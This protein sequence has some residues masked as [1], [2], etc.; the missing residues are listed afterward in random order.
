MHKKIWIV[1]LAAF[2]CIA[3]SEELKGGDS[4]P[5]IFYKIKHGDTLNKLSNKYFKQPVD[6]EIIRNLNNLRTIDLL[7][8]GTTL[9]IP[10][11][12]VKQ[13]P[14][15]A[16][17]IGL[18]CPRTI[19]AGVP[20]KTITIGS[21]LTEGSI[22]DVPAECHASMLLED[23][24]IVRLPSS[25]AIKISTLRR[26]ALE[27]SPEVQLDLVRGK[28]DL[29]VNKA[30]KQN[31]P[32][33]VRTPLSMTGVRGT[34]FRVG[35]APNEQTGEVEVLA[36]VVRA[37]GLN[38]T[39]AQ[40][41]SKGQ[42]MP[43]DRSGKSLPIEKLLSPPALDR[44]DRMPDAPLRYKISLTGNDQA[45]QYV[46][47][48]AKSANLFGDLAS[49]TT[50]TPSVETPVLGQEAVFY[51]FATISKAGLMGPTS[52]YGFCIPINEAKSGRCKATFDAPMT[53]NVSITFS[54][55][56]HTQGI[57]QELVSTKK[58][59]SKNG[60]F[61]IEGL[62]SGQYSWIMSYPTVSAGAPTTLT[63]QTG[64]FDLVTLSA[65]SP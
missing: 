33:D 62:P 45:S 59:S 22:I 11:N 35:Y 24:S 41:L 1:F 21:V 64:T 3:S 26:N 10:R 42:G 44:V 13:S 54:L 50:Q 15:Q 17:I 19:R 53:E 55:T 2:C 38:D 52:Q 51:R 28:I 16:T 25:A 32:F 18:S 43:F 5:L 39:E 6:I 57:S 4:L 65:N 63:R 7:K 36:G 56:K 60:R 9:K 20:L 30:R 48:S 40:S 58:L 27:S 34:E 49:Q 29:E 31:T 23:G 47:T 8:T 37:M 12:F 46:S 14:S 61:T